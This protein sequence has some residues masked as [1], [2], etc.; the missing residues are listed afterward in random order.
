MPWTAAEV[1]A[2]RDGVASHGTGKWAKILLE[3]DDIF[4]HQRT[5][6]NLKDKCADPALQPSRAPHTPRPTPRA[7]RPTNHEPRPAPPPR[8]RLQVAEPEQG[9]VRRRRRSSRGAQT[10]REF[11]AELGRSSTSGVARRMA[12]RTPRGRAAGPAGVVGLL[13]SHP[14]HDRA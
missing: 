12:A 5:S 10:S 14:S 8:R 13:G 7:T 2:L 11:Q 1:R 4:G 3:C 6:V 9:G